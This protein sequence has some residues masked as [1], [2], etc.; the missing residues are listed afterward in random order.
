MADDGSR[1]PAWRRLGLALK[2]EITSG[3]AAPEPSVAQ[4]DT[5]RN[6]PY[7]A[8]NGS[9]DNHQTPTESAVNGKLGK[10]KHQHEPADDEGETAKRAK[11]STTETQS[12]EVSVVDVPVAAAVESA[13]VQTAVAAPAASDT[14]QPKG[15]P[16]YRKKK[17]KPSKPKKSKKPSHEHAP[18]APTSAPVQKE[19]NHSRSSLSPGPAVQKKERRTL[20]ASTELESKP[21]ARAAT[22][23]RHRGASKDSNTSSASPRFDRRKSVTFTPDTKRVD[24]SSAQDL[25][26]KWVADQKGDAA[27]AAAIGDFVPEN[28]PTEAWNA[29]MGIEQPQEEEKEVQ[30]SKLESSKP[31]NAVTATEQKKKPSSATNTATTTQQKEKP[32]LAANTATT[33]PHKEKPSS[34]TATP[35]TA[36]KGKK[37]DPSIYISYLTQYHLDRDHW[38]FNKAKQ[39]DVI[40]NALNV[41]RIPEEHSEAL[42]EYVQ[43]LKG[44]GVIDRLSEKCEASLKD[45]NEQEATSMDDSA[46]RQA[47]Q[48]EALQARISQEQK[49]RKVDLDVE[50]L[51]THPHGDNYIRRLRKER[52]EALLT[53][54]GR[55]VPILPVAHTNAINPLLKNVASARDSKK[56]KRRGDVSSDESSSDSSSDDSSDSDSDSDDSKKFGS[57]SSEAEADS[58]NGSVNGSKGSVSGS[59]DGSDSDSD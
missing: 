46:A 38:K 36:H 19:A 41:F 2:N 56:R 22:P 24:G 44:A 47:L 10:R 25:F 37:K 50:I 58:D 55:A 31:T 3:V 34:V 26:K 53:A 20:L 14:A 15:D 45:L 49:R 1:I 48:D 8:R 57:S 12:I 23:Q 35:S 7:E 32:S 6:S 40:D 30:A 54:L 9:L 11:S 52:A 59:E 16:N 27:F 39:N 43:G 13:S 42:L 4:I 29:L 28:L 17:A 21:I 33:T 5:K 51:E 18:V